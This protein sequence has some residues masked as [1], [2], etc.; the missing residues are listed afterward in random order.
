MTSIQFYHLLTTPLERALPRLLEKA[1]SS[2]FK[3]LLLA[4]SEERAESLNQLLWTY[5][6]DSFLPHGTP[7][8]GHANMQPIL[9]A[10]SPD[11]APEAKL[12]VVTNGATP[13]KPEA[14]ERI[15]DM[16]DGRDVQ[17]VE[18]ARTRW[19]AYKNAGHDVAYLRQNESGGWEKKAVA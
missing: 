7:K 10:T 1:Y 18:Q 19:T 4:E 15:L 12:L 9:I 8:D 5:D 17:A 13:E 3:T 2:G 6:P 16:F 14:F 11:A